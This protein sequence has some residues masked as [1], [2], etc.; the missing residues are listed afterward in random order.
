MM[1]RSDR[2]SAY[3]HNM[4]SLTTVLAYTFE[5]ASDTDDT[6]LCIARHMAHEPLLVATFL[7]RLFPY[8]SFLFV[9]GYGWWVLFWR[10]GR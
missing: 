10:N 6:Q 4:L 3:I 7:F 9:I 2:D 8:V 1:T 5:H